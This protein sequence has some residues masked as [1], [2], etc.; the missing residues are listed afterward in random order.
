MARLGREEGLAA[1]SLRLANGK[2][3]QLAQLRTFSR[4]VCSWAADVHDHCVELV[5]YCGGAVD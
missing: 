4:V 3:I 1:L 5:P 2:R